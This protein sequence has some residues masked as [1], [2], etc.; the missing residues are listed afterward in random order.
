MVSKMIECAHHCEDGF[1]SVHIDC[2]FTISGD[3]ENG[4]VDGV[5]F[6]LE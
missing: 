3:A 4:E 2:G 6:G 1:V 5:G